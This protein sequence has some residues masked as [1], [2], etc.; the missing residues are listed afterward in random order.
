MNKPSVSVRQRVERGFYIQGTCYPAF[1]DSLSSDLVLTS[2]LCTKI[3]LL[4]AF[5]DKPL[6]LDHKKEIGKVLDVSYNKDKG[7][8]GSLEFDAWVNRGVF[9]SP[10]QVESYGAS[11]HYKVFRSDDPKVPTKYVP[12]EISLTHPDFPSTE[13]SFVHSKSGII[14][15]LFYG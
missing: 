4:N 9:G 10:E 13:I 2:T 7:K 6:C 8:N 1:D 3:A 14:F 11:I 12:V 5:K 15:F